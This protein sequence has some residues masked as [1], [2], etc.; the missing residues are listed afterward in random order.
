MIIKTAN[1]QGLDVP[2]DIQIKHWSSETRKAADAGAWA[3]VLQ[4]PL[5]EPATPASV[6]AVILAAFGRD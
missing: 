1:G 3:P 6:A 5:A 2:G 4:I